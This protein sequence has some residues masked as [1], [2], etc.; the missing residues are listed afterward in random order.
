[1]VGVFLIRDPDLTYTAEATAGLF[2]SGMKSFRRMV[3]VSDTEKRAKLVETYLTPL[4]DES[5]LL[6]ATLLN[7]GTG[8]KIFENC[9]EEEYQIDDYSV[10]SCETEN[11]A[12]LYPFARFFAA[13]EKLREA[14]RRIDFV[15][16]VFFYCLAQK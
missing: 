11:A 1:M 16:E 6:Q 9:T 7:I 12:V 5:H 2:R 8:K 15:G 10:F 14:R 3:L 13:H 4:V